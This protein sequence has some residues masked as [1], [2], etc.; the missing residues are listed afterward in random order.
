MKAL[1][2]SAPLTALTL[3]LA[4]RAAAAEADDRYSL[5]WV[6]G[7]GADQCPSRAALAGEVSARLGR[8]PF[9]DDAPRSIEI[10]VDRAGHGYETRIHVRDADGTVLGRRALAH[11]QPD[12]AILFSATALAVALLIDPDA[13]S[14]DAQAVARFDVPEPPPPSAAPER[15]PARPQPPPALPS[16][17]APAAPAVVDA[18]VR[19][20]ERDEHQAFVLTEAVLALGLLPAAAPGAALSA[21]ARVGPRWG[22]SVTTLALP[23][24]PTAGEA[25]FDVGLT[26]FGLAA[27]FDVLPSAAGRLVLE[28]GPA[29]GGLHAIVQSPNPRD[30]GDHWFAAISAGLRG[31]LAV[32]DVLFL[33]ARAA[34][35]VP[36]VRRGL[37]VRGESEPV[38]RQPAIGALGGAGLGLSF[39]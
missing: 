39:F 22:F 27:T 12:C 35:V 25:V 31:Q 21:G 29:V 4:P 9:D 16:A 26:A 18:G 37:F 30:A 13:V 17:P 20:R 1:L 8:A 24:T 14:R 34:A 11:D 19:V 23:A 15:P 10:R 36:V 38:W 32:T 6:R 2:V 28:V 33:G 5:S 7:D 3:A